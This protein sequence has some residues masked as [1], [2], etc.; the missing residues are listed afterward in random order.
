MHK[1]GGAMRIATASLAAAIAFVALP[2]TAATAADSPPQWA[3]PET[4]RNYTPPADDGTLLHVPDSTAGYTWTQLRDRFTAPVWH[5]GDHGPLPDI[6]ANG[7]KPDVLACGFCHRADGPGGPENA[8]LAGLPKSYIIQQMADYKSGARGT[9]VP[10]R[11]PP[12]LM[13]GLAKAATDSEVQTAVAYFSGLKPRKR[14]TVVESDTA[15]KSYIAGVLWAA[16]EGNERE[17]LGG[18][19]L[20][21]PDNLEQFESRDP[22]STFTAYVPVGS[23]AKGEALV[24]KGGG[25]R[26]IACATCHGPDLKGLGPLPSIAGRSPSYIF[27]QLYDFKHGARAGEWSPLMAQVVSNLDQEEMLAIVA[28]LASIDP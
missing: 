9:A 23:L 18:R 22:R 1:I 21:V 3:Y 4:N 6:V 27:R 7:R 13:I 5:P 14:I 10:S 17:P 28:Y 19:I 25:G 24:T 26:T 20:E 12:S 8:D 11:I 15:P 16:A 2:I